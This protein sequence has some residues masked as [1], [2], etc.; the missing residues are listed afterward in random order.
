[1]VGGSVDNEIIVV[2]SGVV[3]ESFLEGGCSFKDTIE[4]EPVVFVH[5][6]THYVTGKEDRLIYGFN[7]RFVVTGK[8]KERT[9]LVGTG[10]EENG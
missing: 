9:I 10:G 8:E 6:Q 5:G 7:S 2:V 4:C 1:M 3:P